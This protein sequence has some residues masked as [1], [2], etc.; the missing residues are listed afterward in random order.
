MA[1]PEI[2]PI[3]T[4]VL[5]LLNDASRDRRDYVR[6]GE[7]M[8]YLGLDGKA[9]AEIVVDLSDKHLVTVTGPATEDRIDRAV[10]AL[11]PSNRGFVRSL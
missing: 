9:L 1:L 3:G 2:S 10:L 7:I 6:G 4:R 8:K 11:H 5:R